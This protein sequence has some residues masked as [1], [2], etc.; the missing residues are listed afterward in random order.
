MKVH[1]IIAITSSAVLMVPIY[2]T[3]A[4]ENEYHHRIVGY[5]PRLE[6]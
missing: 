3:V 2:L 6:L 4:A 5:L 1:R